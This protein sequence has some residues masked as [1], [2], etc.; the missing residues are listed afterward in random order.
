VLNDDFET[1][2]TAH[3]YR[4]FTADELIAYAVKDGKMNYEPG[5]SQRYSHT[6]Y[7]ML[8]EV[9]ERA[10]GK[11]LGEL[12]QTHILGPNGLT[13]TYY[14]QDQEIRRPV[15]HAYTS[16]RKMYEDCTYYNPSW[17]SHPGGLVSNLH[18]M[19][20]WG[21]LFGTGSLV[22]P[23]SWAEMTASTAGQGHNKADLYVCYGFVYANGWYAQN[24][25]MNGY[26]G[27]FAYN[28]S[29]KVTLV[30][31]ATKNENPKIDPAAIS[32]LRE[33]TRYVTPETPLNF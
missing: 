15:L 9:I 26:S 12:Y 22:S 27:G 4:N 16:D 32:I 23:A 7:V 20:K 14:P 21:P 10:T 28:P 19:G 30:V 33:M 11:S 2:V 5:T 13:E 24:P 1:L 18:D 8:G 6:E 3:P 29:N 31:A 17:G 25:S